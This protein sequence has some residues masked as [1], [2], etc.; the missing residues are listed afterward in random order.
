MHYYQSTTTTT[1]PGAGGY[2]YLVIA[3]SMAEFS[4]NDHCFF[5]VVFFLFLFLFY[6]R[7]YNQEKA[8]SFPM[9]LLSS[10]W[11]PPFSVQSVGI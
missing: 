7:S 9:C 8:L 1:S 5:V 11:L 6:H 4:H 10:G 2:C 3:T